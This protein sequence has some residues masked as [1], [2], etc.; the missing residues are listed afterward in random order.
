MS[1]ALRSD[2]VYSKQVQK[3]ELSST[4]EED[5]Q[6]PLFCQ[7]K[8]V[9]KKQLSSEYKVREIKKGRQCGGQKTKKGQRRRDNKLQLICYFLAKFNSDL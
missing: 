1:L 7:E 8:L 6:F 5:K 3:T 4:E 2:S 9:I